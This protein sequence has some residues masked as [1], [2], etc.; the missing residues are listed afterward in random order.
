M[1]Y[2]YFFNLKN[3]IMEYKIY[4]PKQPIS[5]EKKTELIDFLFDQ[6][7]QYGDAREDIEKSVDYALKTSEDAGGELYMGYD[8]NELIGA[9][10][11]N[12]TGMEGYI[13]ENILVYIATHR[14]KRGKGYGKK[15][16]Q[17]VI[18][19]TPGKIKLHVE[20]ENPA[21]FL[22]KKLGFTSKYLEMRLNK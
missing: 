13:P 18:E 12:R 8:N 19:N 14:E 1:R 21:V 15:L 9:V 7:E 17:K 3:Q 10:V 5:N 22:Y 11:M 6:L 20:P 2:Q 4:N 16:M